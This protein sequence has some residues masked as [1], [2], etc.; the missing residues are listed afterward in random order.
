LAPSI[1][2][3]LSQAKLSRAPREVLNLKDLTV[4]SLR[5]N[6]LTELP[7]RI[8]RLANLVELNVSSNRLKWL[9]FSILKLR[10]LRTLSV[11]P[12]PLHLWS[13]SSQKALQ[14]TVDECYMAFAGNF[15]V[16]FDSSS[17]RTPRH[18]GTVSRVA[19]LAIDGFDSSYFPNSIN[20]QL[21]VMENSKTYIPQA[22][23]ST[24]SS[25][26]QSLLE[27][28]LKACS[29][30]SQ[31]NDLP[32]LLG[33]EGPS[34]VLRALNHAADMKDLGSQ[35]C[36]ICGKTFIIPRTEWIEWWLLEGTLTTPIPLIR[37]GCTWSC[38]PSNK[39]SE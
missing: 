11:H 35:R 4:L 14:A 31:F 27:H 16:P 37:R 18:L 10:K 38:F 20:R 12:N 23:T 33:P 6:K 26:C 30:A 25:L 22:P 39:T 24:N 17:I 29:R 32:G 15:E 9:P 36:T 8:D 21:S 34:S 5:N 1:R 13:G 28:A 7:P 19:F 3:F 2:L